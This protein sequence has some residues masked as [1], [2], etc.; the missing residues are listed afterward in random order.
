VIVSQAITASYPGDATHLPSSGHTSL[1]DSQKQSLETAVKGTEEGV[2]P[3][4]ALQHGLPV[5]VETVLPGT[6]EIQVVAENGGGGTLPILK[7]PKEGET[8]PEDGSGGTLPIL[9]PPPGSIACEGGG[10]TLPILR[11]REATA[12][13]ATATTVRLTRIARLKVRLM[14]HGGL[15]KLRVPLNHA[16]RRE[17][18]AIISRDLAYDRKHQHAKRLRP[19]LLRLVTIITFTPAR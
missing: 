19:P 5:S 12:A 15:F 4:Q 16:G 17:L 8:A 6:L 7:L 1:I 10:S 18:K 2:S 9:R 13:S 11:P 14:S 3:A